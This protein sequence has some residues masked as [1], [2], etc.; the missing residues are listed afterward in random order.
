MNFRETARKARLIE[1]GWAEPVVA[2]WGDSP[3]IVEEARLRGPSRGLW[4]KLQRY[5][6]SVPRRLVEV[7]RARAYV[8]DVAGVAVIPP[9]LAAYDSRFGLVPD[10]VGRYGAGA[11]IIDDVVEE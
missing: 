5:A 9:D 6:I 7:W 4:R 2:P 3:V 8:M 11:L 1:D 10:R